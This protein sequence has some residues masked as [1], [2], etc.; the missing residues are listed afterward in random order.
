MFTALAVRTTTAAKVFNI[1]QGAKASWDRVLR[2]MHNENQGLAHKVDSLKPKEISVENLSFKYP[3][4]DEYKLKIFFNI[5]SGKMVGIT[6][7]WVQE[8]RQLCINWTMIMKG[9]L[10]DNMI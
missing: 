4:S 10:L 9:N 8:I 1:Q 6:I 2:L 3:N 5:E 7:L